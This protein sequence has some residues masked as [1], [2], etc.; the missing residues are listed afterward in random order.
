M[1]VKKKGKKR[2]G[3]KKRVSG[4]FSF[5]RKNRGGGKMKKEIVIV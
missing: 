1:G 5:Y 2:E 4:W 3:R